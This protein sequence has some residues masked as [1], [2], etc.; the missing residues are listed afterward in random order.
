MMQS[1]CEQRNPADPSSVGKLV[2]ES[3][4]M[5]RYG[6]NQETANFALFLVFDESSFC[7]GGVIS[8]ME[9]LQ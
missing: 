3:I 4:L 9:A 7:N 8:Q 2:T 5:R 6:S 1:I